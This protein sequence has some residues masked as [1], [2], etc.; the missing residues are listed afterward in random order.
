[1]FMFLICARL[2]VGV[3]F[4]WDLCAFVSAFVFMCACLFVICVLDKTH[5]LAKACV[6]FNIII[7]MCGTGCHTTFL[8]T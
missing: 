1:M 6:I 4:F 3:C 7:S 5:A 2:F 8:D